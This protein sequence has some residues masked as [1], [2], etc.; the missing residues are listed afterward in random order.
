M[1]KPGPSQQSAPMHPVNNKKSPV[2][3]RRNKK[4]PPSNPQQSLAAANGEQSGVSTPDGV[5][6]GGGGNGTEKW[7]SRQPRACDHCDRIFSN[8]FNLKQVGPRLV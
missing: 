2:K 4:S 5:A 6:G 8:K 3:K 7:K 1:T